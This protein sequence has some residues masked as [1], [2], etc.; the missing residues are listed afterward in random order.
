[1]MLRMKL[2][3]IEHA[4]LRALAQLLV[5]KDKGVEAFEEY[6]KLAFPYAEA[7]KRKEK[8][9]YIKRLKSE[10]GR[11]AIRVV[12]LKSPTLTSR[13]GTAKQRSRRTAADPDF[14]RK[15]GRPI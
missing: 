11:G 6:M 3:T 10:I 7:T 14:H 12:P 13:V 4:R 1:M 2:E 15:L 8:D 9:D 5:D